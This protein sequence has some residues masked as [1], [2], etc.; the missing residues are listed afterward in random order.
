LTRKDDFLY[1]HLTD[2][3]IQAPDVV[4]WLRESRVH[5]YISRDK[6]C[7][8]TNNNNKKREKIRQKEQSR[9][10]LRGQMGP[11]CW[12]IAGLGQRDFIPTWPLMLWCV[13]LVSFLRQPFLVIV[14]SLM[15]LVNSCEIF[16][17]CFASLARPALLRLSVS[18]SFSLVRLV[19]CYRSSGNGFD[20]TRAFHASGGQS[21]RWNVGS[22]DETP[23]ANLVIAAEF[24]V[25][26]NLF[27]CHILKPSLPSHYQRA[28]YSLYFVLFVARRSNSR[29]PNL[30]ARQ[31]FLANPSTSFISFSKHPPII[32]NTT[33]TKTRV[34]MS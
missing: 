34:V 28:I 2:K 33:K 24:L 25:V 11:T 32:D 10:M 29:F 17:A 13:R 20:Y 8:N 6:K 19:G 5:V 26:F 12:P 27:Q 31:S 1:R 23:T 15:T 22:A 4:I 3:D 21:S 18:R 14:T 30:S 7:I 16:L 9:R